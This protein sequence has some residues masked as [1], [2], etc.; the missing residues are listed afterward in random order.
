LIKIDPIRTDI[1]ELSIVEKIDNPGWYIFC[2]GKWLKLS[3]ICSISPQ[4]HMNLIQKINLRIMEEP[5]LF[6]IY[7]C[8]VDAAWILWPLD[9]HT[10][11]NHG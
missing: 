3:K 10:I 6:K 7:G 5:Q 9:M 1:G 11:F 8:L 2:D 4:I